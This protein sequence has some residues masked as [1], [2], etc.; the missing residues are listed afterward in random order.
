MALEQI[1]LSA[2]GFFA[3]FYLKSLADSSRQ[4]SESIKELNERVATVIERTE[5]HANEI[6]ILRLR[7]DDLIVDVAKLSAHNKIPQ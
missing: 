7:Q 4:V 2:A 3:A 5:T 6:Q 1:V